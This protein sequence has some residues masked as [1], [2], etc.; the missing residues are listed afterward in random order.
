[1]TL[2]ATIIDRAEETLGESLPRIG[3][4]LL[5]LVLGLVAAWLLGRLTTSAL[6]AVEIDSLAERFGVHDVFERVGL[7]RSLARLL[8][9]VVRVMVAI[10][11][12]IA[13]VTLVGLGALSTS[14][15]EAV[16]FLPK[17]LV[18]LA[19]VLIG[20]I[21]AEFVRDRIDLVADQMAL[22]VPLGR[23]VQAVVLALFVLTGLAL[24]GIPTEILTAMIGVVILAAALTLSL[25]FGLGSRDVARQLSA[26]RYVGAAFAIGQTI[27]ID[28]VSGEIVALET[29][30][31]VLRTADGRIVRVP[32]HLLLESIVTV[33]RPEGSPSG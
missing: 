5:L 1:V 21:V 18:A 30:A 27:S 25:A 4:A 16:L 3:G 17:L 6:R 28:D 23:A 15:N 12:V 10:V 2:A 32:N 9:R 20:V 19:L 31:T 11:V 13:A 26:G 14:L 8:G 22:G 33:Q 7:E 24:L 29:A